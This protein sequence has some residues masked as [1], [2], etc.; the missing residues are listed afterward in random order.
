MSKVFLVTLR[1]YLLGRLL[2]LIIC[3][4]DRGIHYKI[5]IQIESGANL[6]ADVIMGKEGIKRE[7]N[8]IK[9]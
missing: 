9:V 5:R 3:K 6:V 1:M 4:H 8:Y 7:N 2:N